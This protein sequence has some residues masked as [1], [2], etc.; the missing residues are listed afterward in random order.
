MILRNQEIKA[1]YANAHPYQEWLAEHLLTPELL[2][3]TKKQEETA[4]DAIRP[5]GN[6]MATRMRSYAR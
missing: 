5:F 1:H 4:D 6:E 2:P 3:G